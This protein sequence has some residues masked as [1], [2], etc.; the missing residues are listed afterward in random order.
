VILSDI[1]LAAWNLLSV[2][3]LRAKQ[4]MHLVAELDESFSRNCHHLFTRF[5]HQYINNQ[6]ADDSLECDASFDSSQL[7]H[8][9]LV[10]RST[11]QTTI[12]WLCAAIDQSVAELVQHFVSSVQSAAMRSVVLRQFSDDVQKQFPGCFRQNASP[13]SFNSAISKLLVFIQ[14]AGFLMVDVPD[15]QQDFSLSPRIPASMILMSL[16]CFKSHPV[17]SAMDVVAS[18]DPLFMITQSLFRLVSLEQLMLTQICVPRQ[19]TETLVELLDPE[20]SHALSSFFAQWAPAYLMLSPSTYD[21][22]SPAVLHVFGDGQPI[23]LNCLSTLIIRTRLL[24]FEYPKV[25]PSSKEHS[26]DLAT[27]LCRLSKSSQ[28][29]SLLMKIP[30]WVEFTHAYVACDSQNRSL[31]AASSQSLLFESMIVIACECSSDTDAIRAEKFNLVT[32]TSVN[33]LK[34]IL[35]GINSGNVADFWSLF[36]QLNDELFL[37]RGLS[38]ASGSRTLKLKF[39]LIVSLLEILPS[40][41]KTITFI[42]NANALDAARCYLIQ[43]VIHRIIYLFHDTAAAD[44]A[45]LDSE[46]SLAFLRVCIELVR[47][48]AAISSQ[49]SGSSLMTANDVSDELDEDSEDVDQDANFILIMK[50]L[51]HIASKA[52]VNFS[53]ESTPF[54]SEAVLAALFLIAPHIQPER[55][56]LMEAYFDLVHDFL[57]TSP[58]NFLALAQDQQDI[59]STSLLIGLTQPSSGVLIST[60]KSVFQLS[61]IHRSAQ[62]NTA[63]PAFQSLNV[64]ILKFQQALMQMVLVEK[65]NDAV[66]DPLAD[67]FLS[68][69]GCNSEHMSALISSILSQQTGDAIVLARLQGSFQN[70]LNSG[71]VDVLS[72]ERKNRFKFRRLL[73]QFLQSTRGL[74]SRH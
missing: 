73:R 10:A 34:K 61:S 54:V 43:S 56:Q 60:L 70:L 37:F 49:L 68:V 31:L 3:H 25:A 66:V 22:I 23:A 35:D 14:V 9:C 53:D 12:P 38:R 4:Q 62:S 48:F 45:Y 57:I 8:V 26:I 30:A 74:L 6:D 50:L 2:Q 27:M 59:V 39:P 69:F 32:Q 18:V 5:I 13:S 40:I 51:Q 33:R 15:E 63:S 24:L 65:F 19:E 42:P 11:A 64:S 72:I 58:H 29:P 21:L 52:A 20:L 41:F 67:A 1:L 44:I 36:H 71:E 28:F 17:N 46:Q 47:S 55:V 7:K 16:Q